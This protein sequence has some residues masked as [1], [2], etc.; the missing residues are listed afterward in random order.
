MSAYEI[1]RQ[2]LVG[3]SCDHGGMCTDGANVFLIAQH[4]NDSVLYRN[5]EA[6]YTFS[7]QLYGKSGR[8]GSCVAMGDTLVCFISARKSGD[9]QN[10]GWVVQL[11]GCGISNPSGSTPTPTP[12]PTT[13]TDGDI[14]QLNNEIAA[15]QNQVNSLS[16]QVS[17]LS[18]QVSAL[19]SAP[20]G[21]S[22][23]QV[24]DIAWA[25]AND[26]IYAS[27]TGT[28]GFLGGWTW[29]KALDAAYA[30]A[31]DHGLIEE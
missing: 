20:G 26:A 29:Q 4:N 3:T 13:P 9:D 6:I 21:V 22:Q 23:S 31:K 11:G 14:E 30:F 8:S 25:K 19:T 10:S 5:N 7:E 16:K 17:S 12:L 24:E 15:L 28:N 27:A 18:K 2:Q 1:N